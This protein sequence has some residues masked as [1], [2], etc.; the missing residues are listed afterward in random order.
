MKVT[1]DHSEPT[2]QNIIT[3]Y[4]KPDREVRY[5][6]GQ[7]IELR[8]P[9]DNKDSRGDKRWFTLSSSPSE[10]LLSITTKF[11]AEN[12]SSFKNTLHSLQ[13]GA[14]LDMAS[15]MGDFVL[16]KD[17]SIPLVF[18]AGGIGCTPFHS[19]VSY[20]QDSGED[21]NVL[22]LYAANNEGEVAFKDTFSKLGPRLQMIIGERLD[23]DKILEL[24]GEKPDQYIY[25]SGPEPM[26]EALEKGLKTA[27]VNKKHIRTDFFPGYTVI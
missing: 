14:V 15:P 21:R 11:T 24:A 4:F 13:P 7:F 10:D 5:Q 8:L 6:A 12:G 1:F 23:A 16:P 3:F 19:M 26:V 27:G 17:A 22:L 20:L 9:H 18:V 25:L 2:A